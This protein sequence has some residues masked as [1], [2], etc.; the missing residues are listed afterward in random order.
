MRRFDF[1][2]VLCPLNHQ[3][4]R[5]PEYRDIFGALSEEVAR[6]DLGLRTIKAVARK[7]WDEEAE[8]LRAWYEPFTDP[9]DIRAAVSWVLENFSQVTGIASPSEPTLQRLVIDA[10]ANRLDADQADEHLMRV[11]DY[12][13]IFV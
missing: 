12:R 1:D 10:E 8:R 9:D 3:L 6:R 7:P 4:Y 2:S 13:T 5:D 11:D